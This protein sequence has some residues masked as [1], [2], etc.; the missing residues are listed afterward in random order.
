[1]NWA[2]SSGS[3]SSGAPPLFAAQCSFSARSYRY[4]S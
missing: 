1:M 4:L 2:H 3:S